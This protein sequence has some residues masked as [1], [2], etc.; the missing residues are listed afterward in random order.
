MKKTDYQA[1]QAD[2][3]RF[4]TESILGPILSTVGTHNDN[5]PAVGTVDLF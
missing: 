1:P 2:I 3:V 5:A 4:E